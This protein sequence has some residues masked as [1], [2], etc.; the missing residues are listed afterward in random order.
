MP[1]RPRG[2]GLLLLLGAFAVANTA[3]QLALPPYNA[4]LAELVPESD[5][6]KLSGL[7][8]AL[9]YAGS[10]TG[11]LLV[12]PFV[13]GGL[14]IPAG[15]RQAAFTPTALLFVLFSLPFFLFCRDPLALPRAQRPRVRWEAIV[16]ELVSA[17]REARRHRGLTRFVVATY[18]YQ[19]ALGTAISFM[20]LY[21][22]SVLG[23]PPGGEI[24]LFVTLTVPAIAERL[25]RRTRVRPVG[26]EA[27]AA[28]RA[29]R[30][31]RRASPQSRSRRRS[32][33]SGPAVSSSASPSAGSG[34]PSGL[35][36]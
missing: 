28:G 33:D 4:M 34:R 30:L 15:G 1:R 12:A 36:F 20:A 13:T 6:G 11:I 21:A 25:C 14:G 7:G 10:I 9:G 8:T 29:G 31:D 19:D 2:S 26:A 3:Y 24:R 27:D 16:G 5:R 18:F 22:V 23:L 32:P 17:F 35:C